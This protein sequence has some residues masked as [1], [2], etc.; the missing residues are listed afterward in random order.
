L[1][2]LEGQ[3]EEYE[4]DHEPG[5]RI[6]NRKNNGR[7]PAWLIKMISGVCIILVASGIITGI[8]TYAIVASLRTRIEDY[9]LAN[10]KRMDQM[11][12]K[13]DDIQRRLDRGAGVR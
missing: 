9:I 3:I 2:R 6:V 1:R 5:I 10:D 7:E 8:A 12:H 4:R 13:T 11:D